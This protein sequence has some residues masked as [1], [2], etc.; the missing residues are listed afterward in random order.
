[1]R[2]TEAV[3]KCIATITSLH[4]IELDLYT[5][6]KSF[7]PQTQHVRKPDVYYAYYIILYIYTCNSKSDT[8]SEKNMHRHN[9]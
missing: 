5:L 1:M 9:Y 4:R 8:I 6:G 7:C 3:G 2:T